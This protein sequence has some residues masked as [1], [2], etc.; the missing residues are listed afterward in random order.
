MTIKLA[1]IIAE[2]YDQKHGLEGENSVKN[3]PKKMLK[4]I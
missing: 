2:A 1:E 3:N 4:L